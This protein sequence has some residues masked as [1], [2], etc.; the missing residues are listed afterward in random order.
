MNTQKYKSQIMK[1]AIF[2]I[3]YVTTWSLHTGVQHSSY[4]SMAVG[5]HLPLL[6][7]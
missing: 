1:E 3:S 7:W 6:K 2:Y 5:K 4:H